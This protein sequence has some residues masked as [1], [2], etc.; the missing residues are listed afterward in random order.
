MDENV[1]FSMGWLRDLPD[2]RDYDLTTDSL[3]ATKERLGQKS[4]NSMVTELGVAKSPKGTSKTAPP[5]TDL[6]AWCS[7]IENQLNL[8]SCTAHAGVGLLEYFERKASG[9]HVDASRLFLYKV[10][11]NLLGWVGDTGA[12]L[13]TTM[14]ALALL[15]APPERYWKYNVQQF[16]VEPTAFVYSLADNYEAVSYYR[17]DPIGTQPAT[18]LA[19]IK[20]FLQAKLPSMFGFRVY[21]SYT[22]GNATGKIPFPFSGDQPVG[23]HAIVAVGYDDNMTIKHAAANAPTY[24]GALLIRNSWGTGW[25]QAGYGWLPYAYV[26]HGLAVDWWSLLR[27]EWVQTKNFGL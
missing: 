16:D 1:T 18:L 3:S 14:A 21:N 7:P 26:E 27:S 12:Y 25:G 24:K 8:G 15:G 20:L 5:A 13:R 17:L 11:R 22:Q 6:R 19:R 4:V 10:T 2:Y 9:N 23:G